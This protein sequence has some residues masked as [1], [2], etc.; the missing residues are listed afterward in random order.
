MTDI[1]LAEAIEAGVRA[2][3]ADG[4]AEHDGPDGYVIE[5]VYAQAAIHVALTA[6]LPAI[7]E[8]LAQAIQARRAEVKAAEAA[9]RLP[10]R[11]DTMTAFVRGLDVAADVVRGDS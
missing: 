4:L 5:N 8:Q 10:L 2:L 3:V 7:R 9:S 1:D 6:A 11:S